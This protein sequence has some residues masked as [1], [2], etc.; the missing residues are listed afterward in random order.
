[1][2]A[3]L[4]RIDQVEVERAYR[5]IGVLEQTARAIEEQV[6]PTLR[7]ARRRWKKRVLWADGVVF[8]LIAAALIA[9][10]NSCSVPPAELTGDI[11]APSLSWTSCKAI[12]SGD[13]RCSTM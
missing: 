2:D 13:P 4:E 9:S 5:I 1:M 11:S 7:E 12:R 3:I 6:V 8:A 10:A